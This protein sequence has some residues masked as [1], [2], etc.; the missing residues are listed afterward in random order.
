MLPAFRS[1]DGIT[2]VIAPFVALQDDIQHRRRTASISCEIWSP[3]EV[4]NASIFVVTPESLCTKTFNDY[5]NRLM[6]R[7]QLDR[8]VLDDDELAP[9]L[10]SGL[11]WYWVIWV[12]SKTVGMEEIGT[13][14]RRWHLELVGVTPARSRISKYC[15]ETG[16]SNLSLG[17]SVRVP[18]FLTIN[19]CCPF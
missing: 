11:A 15:C 5:T 17:R 7:H 3:G 2:I 6:V 18:T 9:W 16:K 4:P 14:P 10:F 8:V 1:P 13:L 12:Q 19:T